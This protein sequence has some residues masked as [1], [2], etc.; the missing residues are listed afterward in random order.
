MNATAT[1][2]TRHNVT[3]ERWTLIGRVQGL[4]VRPHLA[5]LA[6][7]LGLGGFVRNC[8]EGVE[9]E[10]EGPAEALNSFRDR[11]EKELPDGA[12]LNKVAV[13]SIRPQHR[14]E[15]AIL[16]ST[17]IAK[18]VAQ[19][20]PDRAVCARCLAEV[21]QPGNHR[22]GYSFTCCATCGPR[23]SLLHD[24]PYDRR[25]TSLANFVSCAN[26]RQE[27]DS[28]N[29]RRFHAE[30]IACPTCGP[31]V[32]FT[33]AD[34]HIV[35]ESA[36]AVAAAVAALKRGEI[37]ALRG[38]GGYQLIVDATNESAVFRLRLRKGREAKPFAVMVETIEEA[39]QMGQLDESEQDSLASAVNPIVVVR[40][41][42]NVTIAPSVCRSF[43]TVGLLLPTTPLH[44]Q[45]ANEAACPLIATSGNAEGEPLAYEV[46]HA[47]IELAQ[48]ADVWLHHDRPIVRPIDDS[49]VRVIANRQVTLRLARGLAP[50]PLP[51]STRHSLLAVG[52]HQHVAIALANGSQA[53]LGPYLGDLDGQTTRQRFNE[54]VA[55][56]AALYDLE[57]TL[58]IHDLHPDYFT[59][60]WAR[61]QGRPALAVQ[62]HHAHAVAAMLEQGWLDRE[63]LA[64][65]WDGTGF[66]PD[67]TVW[68]G[69]CLLA[70]EQ[71]FRRVARCRPFALPGGE[72]AIHEPWRV[73]YELVSEALGTEAARQYAPDDIAASTL[74]RL[75]LL[76]TNRRLSPLT[77]SMGRLFDAVACLVL[78]V[79]RASFEGEPAMLLEMACD[80]TAQG[81]Y[82]LPLVEGDL[83]ELDW[84]TTITALCAD[85]AAKVPAATVSMRFHRTLAKA[86]IALAG[87]FSSW[88]VVLAGG[89][90]Q[91]RVLVELIVEGWPQNAG[92]FGLPG[93]IPPG[94]GG[95]AAGQLAVG[96]AY[97]RSHGAR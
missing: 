48:V 87:R 59:T 4:G 81:M 35:G 38:V 31:N 55:S 71:Q 63:V 26:C 73:A 92:Q 42:D 85:R 82:E 70:T 50:L 62:H 66:G 72:I 84:R 91:N 41:R 40:R 14:T 5:R 93:A 74:D 10:I 79:S 11:L 17:V 6:A 45:L 39:V 65:T 44:W 47:Q 16:H 86:V 33:S 46:Q 53:I 77:S 97:L 83:L 24:M 20:P 28:A 88:P 69:E 1:T 57:P 64:F 22:F 51:L 13:A 23:Y 12:R 2:T 25:R 34:Q 19:V 78:G 29:D 89:V 52:G 43:A 15:F 90:F 18:R 21:A 8:S 9:L 94:D 49:V 80:V 30:T 76:S 37:V 96:A 67:G 54:H 68:G 61:S 56:M 3:A 95:L 60:R 75:E 27:Y 7:E 32:W 36:A 58:L